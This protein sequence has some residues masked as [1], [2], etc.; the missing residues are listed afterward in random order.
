MWS[1]FVGNGVNLRGRF[2]SLSLSLSLS[3]PVP[4]GVC[5]GRYNFRCFRSVSVSLCTSFFTVNIYRFLSAF[6][7]FFN[8]RKKTDWKHHS[9]K[10][11]YIRKYTLSALP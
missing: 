11:L 1:I 6:F 8:A 4:S 9:K 3:F 2:F 7:L 10:S 5:G